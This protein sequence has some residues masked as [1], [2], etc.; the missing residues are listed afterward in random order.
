M[1]NLG[2]TIE[3]EVRVSH[4]GITV[5]K[6]ANGNFNIQNNH[7]VGNMSSDQLEILGQVIDTILDLNHQTESEQK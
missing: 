4:E 5:L 7:G 3:H 6:K 2:M 1:E